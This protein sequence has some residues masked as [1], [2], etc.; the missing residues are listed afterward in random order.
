M[1]K[2]SVGF[3]LAL[4]TLLFLASGCSKTERT[5][6]GAAIGAGGGALI[7]GAAGGTGGAVAGGLL[8]GALGGL[9]GNA[10]K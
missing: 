4:G 9:L 5:V 10:S 6:A 7:G 3:G 2:I 8:G 1:K